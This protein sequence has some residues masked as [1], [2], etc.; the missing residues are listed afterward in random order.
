[1]P[2]IDYSFRSSAKALCLDC[3]VKDFWEEKKKTFCFS[4]EVK[5]PWRFDYTLKTRVGVFPYPISLQDFHSRFSFNNPTGGRF[6]N[7]D[8]SIDAERLSLEVA[9][10]KPEEPFNNALPWYETNTQKQCIAWEC[11]VL[12]YRVD[13][14]IVFDPPPSG[15]PAV[16]REWSRRFFPGGLPSLGKRR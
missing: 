7:I 11:V 12:P 9:L 4:E 3:R 15:P 2:R 1:M 14:L 16:E 10:S 13:L 5:I 8:Y 6:Q